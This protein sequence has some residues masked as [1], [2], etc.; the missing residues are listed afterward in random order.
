MYHPLSTLPTLIP[1]ITLDPDQS[2]QALIRILLL[3]SCLDIC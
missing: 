1:F 3:I 2:S